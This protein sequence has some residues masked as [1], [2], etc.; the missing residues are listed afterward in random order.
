MPLY[1]RDAD[2][3]DYVN[4]VG[5]DRPAGMNDLEFYVMD[6]SD[7]A[8]PKVLDNIF[9]DGQ[10]TGHGHFTLRETN[11]NDP[12]K[13]ISTIESLN[14][15]GMPKAIIARTIKGRGVSFIENQPSWHHKV[16]TDEE[17]SQAMKEL[18]C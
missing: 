13:F 5:I 9:T 11:G 17:L 16:P 3:G 8:N 15:N 14:E 12:G 18:S 2:T 7:P 6:Y 10:T 1:Y 4:T